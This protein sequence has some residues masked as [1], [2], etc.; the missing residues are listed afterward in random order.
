MSP[1][2]AIEL[3]LAEICSERIRQIKV[4]GYAQAHDDEHDRGELALAAGTYALASTRI[5][6]PGD[7]NEG[8]GVSSPEDRIEDVLAWW[9][10]DWMFHIA[11]RRRMLVKAGA[12][13]VAE[14]ERLDRAAEKASGQ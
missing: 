5:D 4:E 7:T 10:I 6:D 2:A 12:L 13:I 3:V 8:F 14:I 11:H 9:P 1:A